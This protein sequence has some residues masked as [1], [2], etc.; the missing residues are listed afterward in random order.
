M[1]PLLLASRL[2]H[3]QECCARAAIA[4]VQRLQKSARRMKALADEAE[5]RCR[6]ALAAAML[7]DEQL[8]RGANEHSP[9]ATTA[10]VAAERVGREVAERTLRLAALALVVEQECR[11]TAKRALALATVALTAALQR[12]DAA[13]CT[14]ALAIL[15]LADVQ[16]CP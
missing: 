8:C 10:I 15:M 12:R 4:E 13:K 14:S 2:Q 7:A 1:R 11:E 3:E 5:K 9:L 6:E 16:K